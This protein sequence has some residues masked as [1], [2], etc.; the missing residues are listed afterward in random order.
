MRWHESGQASLSGELLRLAQDADAAFVRLAGAWG[1]GAER[2]PSTL[3][4]D[5]L[6]RT[7]YLRSFPHQATFAVGFDPGALGDFA[8]D[9]DQDPAPFLGAATEILTPAACYHL[10]PAHEGEALAEPL[11]LTTVNTCYRREKEYVPLRRQWSFTM[12]EIVCLG[13][14]E[15]TARFARRTTE[16][17]TQL[18]ELAGLDVEWEHA[19]DPFFEPEQNPAFLL[20]KLSPVKREATYGDLA[21]ASVNLHH[22][23][24]G[25]AFGITRAGQDAHSACVAFGLERW[26]AAIQGTHGEDPR[27]WPDLPALAAE[28]VATWPRS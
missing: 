27:S 16:A 14:A 19:T 23:H 2:H 28:V 26:L 15:E 9:P 20:Q 8:K 5:V 13:T 12:R 18:F 7:G 17:V 11:Y 24:F 6:R 25:E 22:E 4:A 3:P 10:Y 1:A 21:I